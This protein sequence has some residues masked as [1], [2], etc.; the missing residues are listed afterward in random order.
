MKTGIYKEYGQGG[1]KVNFHTSA[2]T[3]A[4]SPRRGWTF[5]NLVKSQK[6]RTPSSV[7]GASFPPIGWEKAG[8]RA[9]FLCSQFIFALRLRSFALN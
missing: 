7:G 9:E 5:G 6:S 1:S 8:A 2:L 4:L 3:L